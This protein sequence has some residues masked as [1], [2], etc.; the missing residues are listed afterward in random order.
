MSRESTVAIRLYIKPW[1]TGKGDMLMISVI[2]EIERITGSGA[3]QAVTWHVEDLEKSYEQEWSA[4]HEMI[5]DGRDGPSTLIIYLENESAAPHHHR[6]RI[7][8]WSSHGDIDLA[9]RDEN[10]GEQLEMDMR[11]TVAFLIY[12]NGMCSI[13]SISSGSTTG[14]G[15]RLDRAEVT[16]EFDI[17]EDSDMER[18]L[19]N[20]SGI[21]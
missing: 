4:K 9:R 16:E 19:P 20:Q 14:G 5:A 8:G 2:G 3:G 13:P 21:C 11:V 12:H 6:W 18:A 17:E 7:N 15:G 10:T 1:P